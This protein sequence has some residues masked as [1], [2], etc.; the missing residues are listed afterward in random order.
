MACLYFTHAVSLTMTLLLPAIATNNNLNNKCCQGTFFKTL[1]CCSFVNNITVRSSASDI[2]CV[3]AVISPAAQVY[4]Y[5]FETKTVLL[6]KK[7]YNGL[8]LI[9]ISPVYLASV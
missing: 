8:L 4:Q 3:I 2:A 9:K 6:P 5:A 7:M 1:Q